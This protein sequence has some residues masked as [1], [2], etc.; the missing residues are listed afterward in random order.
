MEVFAFLFDKDEEP[1]MMRKGEVDLSPFDQKA[2]FPYF[3]ANLPPGEYESRI[4]ARDI[5]TGHS[6]VGKI[7]FTLPEKK[8]SDVVLSTPLLF[9][10]GPD[11]QILRLSKDPSQKDKKRGDSLSD[12]YR[13]HPKNHCI[14]VRGIGSE[15]KSLLAVIPATVAE[16]V[17][18]E[19]ELNVRL[20]P[21]PESEPVELISEVVDVQKADA[22]TD[23]LMMEILLPDLSPGEYE[24]EIEAFDEITKARSFVRKSL[25]IK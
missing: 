3:T 10:P 5:Q 17:F 2:L 1:V 15:I 8:E 24:L 23:V 18:P 7:A 13:F 12:L 25:I 9:A 22:N 20:Y 11:S 4:V 21:K 6:V 16:G 14:V 19:V